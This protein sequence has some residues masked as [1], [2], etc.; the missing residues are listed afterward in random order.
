MQFVH[1]VVYETPAGGAD[2][3]F[4]RV[5]NDVGDLDSHRLLGEYDNIL[6]QRS[7]CDWVMETHTV[8]LDAGGA[9]SVTVAGAIPAGALVVGVTTRVTSAISGAAG[10][11]V[12]TGADA[13]RFG[14]K[15]GYVVGTTT[16]NQDWTVGTVEVFPAATDIVITR[17]SGAFNAGTLLLCVAYMRAVSEHS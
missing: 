8:S 5:N 10:Y 2:A 4:A 13:D 9:T 16:D 12:G 14:L 7:Y 15:I 1:P 17:S 11:A 3:A 6:T